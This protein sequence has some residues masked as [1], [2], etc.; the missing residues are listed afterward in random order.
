MAN[1]TQAAQQQK[2]SSTP[3]F[4]FGVQ[5]PRNA[6]HAMQLD[7]VNGDLLWKEATDLELSSINKFKTFRVLKKGEA[8]PAGYKCIPYHMIYDVKFDGRRK[9]RLVAGGHR[10]PDVPPEEVYSGVVSMDTIRMVFVIAALN[11]LDV[12]AA[13]ISTAFLYGKT[14]EKVYVIA[15]PEFGDLAGRPMIIDKGLYGLKSSAARFHE[16]L[17]SKLRSMG[18]KPSKADHDLWL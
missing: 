14:R 18:F 1:K 11:G 6:V 3:K 4:K 8:I 13:D 2:S 7:K 15:G 10:T 9:C 16:H 17:S 5:V 12:C